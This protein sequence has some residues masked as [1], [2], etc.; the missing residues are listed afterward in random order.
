MN[1]ETIPLAANWKM[2]HLSRWLKNN[3]KKTT[4]LICK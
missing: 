2:K 1:T 3:V 4:E